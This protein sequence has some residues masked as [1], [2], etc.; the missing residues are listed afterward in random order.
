MCMYVDRSVHVSHMTNDVE[1]ALISAKFGRHDYLALKTTYFL[2]SLKW[3]AGCQ[4]LAIQM[5]L[6]F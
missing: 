1:L 4:L 5:Q 3:L 6:T 2:R